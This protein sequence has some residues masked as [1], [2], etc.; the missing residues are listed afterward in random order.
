MKPNKGLAFVLVGVAFAVFGVS[1]SI[2][3]LVIATIGST[4]FN[5][6]VMGGVILAFVGFLLALFSAMTIQE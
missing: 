5:L 3:G 4:N 6:A 1:V 2:M